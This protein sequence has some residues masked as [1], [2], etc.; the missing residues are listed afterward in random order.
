MNY[1]T[2]KGP[3]GITWVSI[4]PLMND[5]KE[6]VI[7]LMNLEL[8]EQEEEGRNKK[9]MGLQATYEILGALIQESNLKE[10]R[11]ATTH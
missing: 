9:I 7:T 6:S 8:P 2:T 1:V 10:A 5:L 11:N 3:D 4:E